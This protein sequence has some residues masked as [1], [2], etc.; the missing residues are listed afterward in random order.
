MK[1]R[2]DDELN[3]LYLSIINMASLAENAVNL[4][5]LEMSGEK[6][7]VKSLVEEYTREIERKNHDLENYCVN[8]LL[9]YHPVAKDLRRIS[10]ATKIVADLERIGDNALDVAEVM[11]YCTD[12][13]LYSKIFLDKMCLSV[14]K[15]VEKAVQSYVSNDATK[16]LEV[17]KSDDIVDGYFLKAKESLIKL[18]R[19]NSNSSDEAPDLMMIA[20]YL[21]RMGDHAASISRWV[22]YE[23][24][25]N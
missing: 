1:N 12:Q 11:E 21:E 19:Q 16:A 7:G 17:E 5:S 25:Y 18:I 22:I 20:K 3:E 6:K 15:M 13:S 24:N 14:K 10:S 4:L 2:F 23:N 8:L 9:R